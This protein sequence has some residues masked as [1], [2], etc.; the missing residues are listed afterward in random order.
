MAKRRSEVVTVRLIPEDLERLRELAEELG[1]GPAV[2][3]RIIIRQ[4]LKNLSSTSQARFPLKELSELLAPAVQ[5]Q[6]LSE[7]E[8]LEEVRAIRQRIYEERYNSSG[9][10]T[11]QPQA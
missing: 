8:L 4:G 2:L 7:E 10:R 1:V 5:A 11:A 6:G 3:A 9:K